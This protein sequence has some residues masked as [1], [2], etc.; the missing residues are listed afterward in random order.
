MSGLKL[1]FQQFQKLCL[2]AGCDYVENVKGIGIHKG[3]M[4]WFVVIIC[5]KNLQRMGH[6][7]IMKSISPM[8]WLFLTIRQSLALAV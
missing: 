1:S 6:Q 4:H 3:H 5:L 8:P 2:A 7:M